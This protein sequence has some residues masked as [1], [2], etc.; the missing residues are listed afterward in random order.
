MEKKVLIIDGVARTVI[1]KSDASFAKVLREQLGL[2]GVKIG[3]G[4]AQCGACSVILDGKVVRSCSTKMKKVADGAQITTIEGVGTA[5]NLLPDPA[6]L[7]G[8]RRRPVRLLQPGFI[9]SAK[10]LWDQN[11]SPTREDVRDWFQKHRNACRCTATS[12]WWMR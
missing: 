10:G 9:V 12:P 1:A 5:A 3:C 2:T 11:V 8:S 6:C 7:D 4:G